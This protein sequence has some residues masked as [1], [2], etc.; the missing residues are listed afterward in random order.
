VT[1][2]RGTPDEVTAA[3]AGLVRAAE[4]C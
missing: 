2:G 1:I 3:L 4:G